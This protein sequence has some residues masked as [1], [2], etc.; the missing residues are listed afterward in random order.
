V[1]DAWIRFRFG[2][3]REG[4]RLCHGTFLLISRA[5]DENMNPNSSKKKLTHS[6][7][8]PLENEKNSGRARRAGS[9]VGR[10][11]AGAREPR[12]SRGRRLL[13]GAGDGSGRRF[14]VWLQR[15]LRL[16]AAGAA[17]EMIS[18]GIRILADFPQW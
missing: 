9:W 10:W 16:G 13:E 1:K 18:G 3:K 17:G 14:C 4:A 8:G 6:R 5:A 2:T 15:A 12:G 7:W 11:A